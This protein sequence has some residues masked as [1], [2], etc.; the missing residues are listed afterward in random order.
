M[1][2]KKSIKYTHIKCQIY[3]CMY[4]VMSVCEINIVVEMVRLC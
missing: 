4:Q 3:M 2:R 1:E